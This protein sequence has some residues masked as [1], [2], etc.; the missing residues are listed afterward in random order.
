MGRE[1]YSIT[2]N[3]ESPRAF[4]GWDVE[5]VT[6]EVREVL[7]QMPVRQKRNSRLETLLHALGV[8]IRES[9]TSTQTHGGGFVRCA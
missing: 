8:G 1:T 9:H 6:P 4:G 7:R 3:P 5:R 2:L